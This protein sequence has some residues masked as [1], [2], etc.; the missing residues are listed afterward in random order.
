MKFPVSNLYWKQHII[1]LCEIEFIVPIFLLLDG[2]LSGFYGLAVVVGHVGCYFVRP[3]A[4]Y[5]NIDLV[6]QY[7]CSHC[8]LNISPCGFDIKFWHYWIVRPKGRFPFVLHQKIIYWFVPLAK[9]TVRD[10]NSIPRMIFRPR[11]IS[12]IFFNNEIYRNY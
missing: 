1:K 9:V 7:Q 6:V 4:L 12:K 11:K 10:Y 8:K 3:F 5:Q 2:A